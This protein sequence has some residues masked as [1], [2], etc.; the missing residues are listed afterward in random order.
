MRKKGFRMI[1][2]AAMVMTTMSV[3]DIPASASSA[4]ICDSINVADEMPGNEDDSERTPDNNKSQEESRGEKAENDTLEETHTENEKEI[5]DNKSEESDFLGGTAE[6]LNAESNTEGTPAEGA[7]ADLSENTGT[8]NVGIQDEQGEENSD[9]A[10]ADEETDSDENET[11]E[12]IEDRAGREYITDN[13]EDPAYVQDTAPDKAADH[14]AE[15]EPMPNGW[16]VSGK[17]RNFYEDGIKKTGMFTADGKTY[18]ADENGSVI[19][20]QWTEYSK[21]RYYTDEN[22][23]VLTGWQVLN[24]QK[25]YFADE[26]LS[27]YDENIKGKLITAPSVIDGK[28]YYF[29]ESG[30]LETDKWIEENGERVYTDENGT[31]ASGWKTIL[32]NMYYLKGDGKPVIG[33]KNING[34]RYFD[35][36]GKMS[37]GWKIINGKTY[38]FLDGRASTLTASNKGSLAN[39][40]IKMSGKNVLYFKDGILTK[41]PGWLRT[42]GKMYYFNQNGA[43]HKGWLKRGNN[44]FYFDGNGVMKT[45]WVKYGKNTYFMNSNGTMRTGWLGT[46]GKLYFFNSDGSMK[47]GWFRRGSNWFYFD[48]NGVMKTGWITSGGKKYY[49]TS[50]GTKK[51][52]W[53]K[54]NGKM[55][56]LGN[57]GF[58][59][60]G[61]IKKN[62]RYYYFNKDGSMQTGWKKINGNIFVFNANGVMLKDGWKKYGNSLYYL[63]KDGTARIGWVTLNGRKYRFDTKGAMMKGAHKIGNS[64]YVF[65]TNGVMQKNRWFVSGGK[66]YRLSADGKA[67]TGWQVINGN[68]Y[69]FDST[70]IMQTGTRTVSGKQYYFYP[71]GTMASGKWISRSGKRYYYKKDGSAASGAFKIDGKTYRFAKDGMLCTGIFEQ[72]GKIY[73]STISGTIDEVI[74]TSKIISIILEDGMAVSADR[75]NMYTAANIVAVMPDKND[76]AQKWELIKRDDGTYNIKNVLN[77]MYLSAGKNSN[78]P[79]ITSMGAVSGWEIGN[80]GINV[81]KSKNGNKKLCAEIQKNTTPVNTKD[82]HYVDEEKVYKDVEEKLA[83]GETGTYIVKDVNYTDSNKLWNKFIREYI[84]IDGRASS[85][86]NMSGTINGGTASIDL[87]KALSIYKKKAAA[88]K[89]YITAEKK[90]GVKPGMTN[91]EK[92]RQIN[93]Y[94]C[95]NYEW[96]I[97][98]DSMYA[99]MVGKHGACVQHSMLF[100]YLCKKSGVTSEIVSLNGKNGIGHALNRVYIDGKWYYCDTMFNNCCFGTKDVYE[101]YLFMRSLKNAP[102]N[103]YKEYDLDNISYT[104]RVN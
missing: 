30:T 68:R 69:Y 82:I 101:D 87:T 93:R 94:I 103:A 40:V 73:L 70:G 62:G 20:D 35:S 89:A 53:L 27:G 100:N 59:R 43:A 64:V 28:K 13:S 22:G 37:I 80:N 9:S 38:Y 7:F 55:Y 31:A 99:M 3:S 15:N 26:T 58:V 85:V 32:G 91:R 19:C 39:G 29:N 25:C 23:C 42:A 88:E 102:A 54:V 66:K 60:T 96:A 81:F 63:N 90:C 98:S 65:D 2:A 74:D 71:G 97:G 33:W 41:R 12:G 44:W 36:T 67:K 18:I 24:G 34:M 72:D 95:L 10:Q 61:W 78:Y 21:S 104:D 84:D 46:G 86:V 17:E 79:C 49:M 8:D 56:Y 14:T 47:K 92:V 75:N 76:N 52:G 51:T 57:E 1:L 11:D 83:A 6:S 16:I 4:E 77:R 5:A 45:G 50:K 48:G